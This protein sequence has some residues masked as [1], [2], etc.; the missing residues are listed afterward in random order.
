MIANTTTNRMV[1]ISMNSLWMCSVSLAIGVTGSGKLNLYSACAAPD[2][3]KPA[4]AQKRASHRLR[5]VADVFMCFPP[6]QTQWLILFP[7][8]C[9]GEV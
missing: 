5:R 9:D 6:W 8:P 7:P 4:E 3:S 2:S 1:M